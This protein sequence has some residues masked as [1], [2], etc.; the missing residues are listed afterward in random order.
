M[1]TR[2]LT[3]SVAKG[4]P[5]FDRVCVLAPEQRHS[6]ILTTLLEAPTCTGSAHSR[7]TITQALSS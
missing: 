5:L 2:A 3:T 6:E 1:V 4:Q 7:K